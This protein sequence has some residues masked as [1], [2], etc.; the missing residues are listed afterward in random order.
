MD[1][2]V[3]ETLLFPNALLLFLLPGLSLLVL[4]SL[5]LLFLSPFNMDTVDHHSSSP[6]SL[7][8]RAGSG[9]LYT[10]IISSSFLYTWLLNLS[11]FMTFS[12]VESFSLDS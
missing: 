9:V 3:L 5:F 6:L 7:I 10:T 2:F 12:S 8:K 11:S 1:E 4:C